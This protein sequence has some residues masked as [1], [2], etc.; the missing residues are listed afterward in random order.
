MEGHFLN[1]VKEILYDHIHY[2][3]QIFQ[4]AK[5]DLIK[6]YTG[7]A[8]GWA[9][10]II[11]PTVTIFVFWFAFT[12]GLRHGEP[13]NGYPFFL[14]L[15]AGFVPW[16]FMRDS[17]TSGA[18]SI[19]KYKYLVQRIKYPVDTIPTFVVLSQ[20]FSNLALTLIM[21]VIYLVF[22][23]KPTIYYLQIPLF[24]LM[25]LFFFTCWGLFSA[26]LS[27][28]SKDFFNLVKSAVPP[29]FWL[30]G[31]LY[32]PER[33]KNHHTI[34][35]ILMFNPV[36]IIVNGFRNSFVYHK[37]FWETPLLIRNYCI[38]TVI[39]IILAIWA[40]RKLK[41]EIPDVL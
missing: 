40:Y 2:R 18:G 3:K 13:Q 24:Y 17:I 16:F 28:M 31:I 33:I 8:F 14:W 4:L 12:I 15:I 23:Y 35:A 26:M 11:K 1:T 27:S 22:G 29:L 30:S 36:T 19:R 20:L 7:A 6:T 34:R 25:A 10:A 41:K 5:S 37:W 38:V 32:S 21:I 9:W 39:M